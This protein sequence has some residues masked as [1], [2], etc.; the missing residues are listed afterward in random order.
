VLLAVPERH[1]PVSI[2]AGHGLL[3]ATTLVLVLRSAL[4]AQR[5]ALGVG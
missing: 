3:G 4:S 2:V 1:F 5:S